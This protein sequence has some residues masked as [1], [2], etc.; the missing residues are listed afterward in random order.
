[1]RYYI[2][3]FVVGIMLGFAAVPLPARSGCI[4][5]SH[6]AACRHNPFRAPLPARDLIHSGSLYFG[7]STIVI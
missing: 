1:M 7:D 2:I 4:A 5:G 3:P 6:A